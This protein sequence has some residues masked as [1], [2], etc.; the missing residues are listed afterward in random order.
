M[1]N[2]LFSTLKTIEAREVYIELVEM[3]APKKINHSLLWSSPK[4]LQYFYYNLLF[5][6]SKATQ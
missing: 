4:P 5:L 6:R 1:T 3:L 2:S